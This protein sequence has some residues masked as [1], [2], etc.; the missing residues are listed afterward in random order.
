M[1]FLPLS[2]RGATSY[3]FQ[4][5]SRGTG[6][7]L[8]LPFLSFLVFLVKNPGWF[9][10][11]KAQLHKQNGCHWCSLKHW[12]VR[13]I[14]LWRCGIQMLNRD[15]FWQNPK[16]LTQVCIFDPDLG[17][18]GSLAAIAPFELP[19]LS[20]SVNL[21][22]FPRPE[23]SNKIKKFPKF[24]IVWSCFLWTY[25][26]R[27][28]SLLPLPYLFWSQIGQHM[29]CFALSCNSASVKQ[30]LIKCSYCAFDE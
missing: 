19:I 26:R 12:S 18:S 16:Y 29:L 7:A 21:S 5:A 2:T 27:W 9:Y 14:D 23:L 25:T 3:E 15:H 8:C 4:S 22:A 10:C 24:F 17:H 1:P 20:L 11:K 6:L 28:V 13:G 30:S